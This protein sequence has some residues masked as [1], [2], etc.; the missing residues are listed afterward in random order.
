MKNGT[1]SINCKIEKQTA[2]WSSW[3]HLVFFSL[4]TGRET[5]RNNADVAVDYSISDPIVRWDSYENFNL[6]YEDS[7]E[8]IK[9]LIQGN[10][11]VLRTPR[12][13]HGWLGCCFASVQ[14]RKTGRIQHPEEFC[15]RLNNCY[16]TS[17]WMIAWR[18]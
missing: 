8:G 17:L 7:L 10:P 14:G 4:P 11:I 9:G 5:Y 2:C 13:Y 15:F 18:G 6:Q 3:G 16:E 1:T 12:L